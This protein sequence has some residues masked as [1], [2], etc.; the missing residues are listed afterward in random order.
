[1]DFKL[2]GTIKSIVD[3][4]GYH[5]EKFL[6]SRRSRMAKTVTIR[7]WLQPFN[8]FYFETLSFFPLFIFFLF[9]T[10][11]SGGLP[12]RVPPALIIY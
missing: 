1:M 9:A 7:L 5:Q 8:T 2:E 10:Q 6:N 4:H 11:K 12:P 3:H